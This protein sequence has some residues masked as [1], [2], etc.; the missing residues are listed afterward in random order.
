MM[1]WSL[2]SATS[3]INDIVSD[4][5]NCDARELNWI[6]FESG[7][8]RR[9]ASNYTVLLC[10]DCSTKKQDRISQSCIIHGSKQPPISPPM[11]EIHS[12]HFAL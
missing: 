4:G 1:I 6:D 12:M 9:E 7:I 10:E 11:F 2:E 3:L 8:V 5:V